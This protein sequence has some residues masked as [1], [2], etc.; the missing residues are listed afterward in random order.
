MVPSGRHLEAA[1][2]RV[3][4]TKLHNRFWW[5][6]LVCGPLLPSEETSHSHFNP[7]ERLDLLVY[8]F[9]F[10]VCATV[11][12][13]NVKSWGC[14]KHLKYIHGQSKL[15]RSHMLG[16]FA[17][18]MREDFLATQFQLSHATRSHGEKTTDTLERQ[19]NRRP[20]SSSP[21]SVFVT[22]GCVGVGDV[23]VSV[24]E[25]APGAHPTLVG[26]RLYAIRCCR[27]PPCNEATEVKRRV[28]LRYAAAKGHAKEGRLAEDEEEGVVLGFQ[29]E[30]EEEEGSGHDDSD[31][32]EPDLPEDT[33][34]GCEAM[35]CNNT[36]LE[37]VASHDSK[38]EPTPV[39]KMTNDRRGGG[40]ECRKEDAEQSRWKRLLPFERDEK[41]KGVMW[42]IAAT[43]AISKEDER[44]LEH[45]EDERAKEREARE[46]RK[47][48]VVNIARKQSVSMDF[49][50]ESGEDEDD[51]G[52]K[53]D[54]GDDVEVDEDNIDGDDDSSD[55]EVVNSDDEDD[56][57][58]DADAPLRKDTSDSYDDDAPL[59]PF[60]RKRATTS[61]SPKSKRRVRC[62]VEGCMK[63]ASRGPNCPAHGGGYKCTFEGCS[64]RGLTG[65][66][67]S[68]HRPATR[69][70]VDGCTKQRKRAGLCHAHG[71]GYLC[72]FEGC[73]KNRQKDK[74]CLAHSHEGCSNINA[75]QDAGLCSDHEKA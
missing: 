71:V 64:N 43:G 26:E 53:D 73:T 25:F 10:H 4:W 44:F 39:T 2:P 28:P 31:Y 66:F 32:D 29:S 47:C 22:E 24:E 67:C 46:K 19:E 70:K 18:A 59:K 15:Y 20:S 5:P 61:Q 3:A 49:E 51:T 69:C 6:I 60:R 68:R 11:D 7:Q 40:R 58:D 55:D 41:E 34:S 63:H 12:L 65:R 33:M 36:A 8:E 57:S 14:R 30:D 50:D 45:C 42:R 35:G 75:S 23:I 21:H 56:N 1:L 74:F 38:K 62:Q 16:L 17:Q 27:P 48:H 37:G 52:D 72:V 9:G 54:S 13:A